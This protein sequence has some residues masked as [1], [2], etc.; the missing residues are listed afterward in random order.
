MICQDILEF[1]R[2]WPLLEKAVA[3]EIGGVS[4]TREDVLEQVQR[5]DAV[6]FT[7]PSSATLVTFIH[8]PQVKML[9]VWAA[10]GK[11][12]EII[13]IGLDEIEV[14]AR[15]NEYKYIVGSAREAWGHVL[16]DKGFES[17]HVTYLKELK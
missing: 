3:K 12:R 9:N 13:G 7:T 10:G 17:G 14:F 4:H 5:G 16:R 8:H 1:D 11:L 6:I 15:A 2:V